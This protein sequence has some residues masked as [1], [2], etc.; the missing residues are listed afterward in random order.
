LSF[1]G[2]NL[3]Q[4][5]SIDN[6]KNYILDR[7]KQTFPT[8]SDQAVLL[9]NERNSPQFLLC[10]AGSNP[11]PQSQMLSLRAANHILLHM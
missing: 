9:R 8:V 1:L 6:I 2:E 3:L 11:S 5:A 10:F 7:L 4:K